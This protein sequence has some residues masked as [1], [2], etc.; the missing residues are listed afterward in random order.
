MNEIIQLKNNESQLKNEIN[1]LKNNETQ[2]KNEI[3]QLKNTIVGLEEKLNF[4]WKGKNISKIIDGNKKYYESLKN[5]INP[6]KNIKA[7]LLYRLSENGDKYSTLHELCDNKGPTL[8]L[9]HIKN[10]NKIGIYTPLSWDTS[11]EWKGDIETFIFNL[12]KNEKYK[13]LKPNYSIFPHP[14]Y[15]P[16][17]SRLGC[18][19]EL[20]C[21]GMNSIFIDSNKLII[22]MIKD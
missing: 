1:E 19:N 2:S 16:W 20:G 11:K 22:I 13:K 21:N 4:L 9:F 14:S 7:E 17:T 12:N 6:S 8:T 18:S 10:G 5:W 3:S 15:G